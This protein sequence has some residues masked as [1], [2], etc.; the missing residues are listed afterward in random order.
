M[1]RFFLAQTD[2]ILDEKVLVYS[3]EILHQIC[4]VLKLRMGE[5]VAFMN[6]SGFEWEVCLSEI[7][8]NSVIGSIIA[9]RTCDTELSV[10]VVVAQSMLKNPEKFEFVLQKGTE[11]GMK[12]FIPLITE[13]TEQR[14]LHK[15]E[16]LERI[17]KESSEQCGRCI[18]P[19]LLEPQKFGNNFFEENK[20]KVIFVP[21]P[22]S[23]VKF[24]DLKKKLKKV[25]SEVIICVGPEGG[26][27][28]KEI[29]FALGRGVHVFSLGRRV[30]RAETASVVMC[31][32]LNEWIGEM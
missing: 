4:N 16:R 24:S 22:D 11:L 7:S 31:A 10:S 3:P 23:D 6:N 21:H 8:S 9:K 20:G 14:F 2:K 26:F 18:I 25:L 19:S 12:S 15:K 29:E 32:L 5:H 13:R 30:L 17:L 1:H 28:Q 27:S